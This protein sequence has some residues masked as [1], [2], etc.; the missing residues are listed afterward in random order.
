VIVKISLEDRNGK[1]IFSEKA[2]L[3]NWTWS[4]S[5]G[6]SRSD[7]Y[8]TKTMFIPESGKSYKVTLKIAESNLQ[9]PKCRLLF[10][11]GGWKAFD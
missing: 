2:S 9:M 4:G 3:K 6:A 1:V 5:V 7:L 8:T 11:G 10:M